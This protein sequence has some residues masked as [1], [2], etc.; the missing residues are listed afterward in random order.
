M[1]CGILDADALVGALC[2]GTEE[3][4]DQ[5]D[6]GRRTWATK[7]LVNRANASL[8]ALSARGLWNRT[9]RARH[10]RAV[11]S[12]PEKTREHLLRLSMLEERI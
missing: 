6:V 5:Y 2:V 3:A 7:H 8:R 11:A 9:T 4:L 12:S 1:N 10:L